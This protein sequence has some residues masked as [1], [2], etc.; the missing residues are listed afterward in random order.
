MGIAYGP[1]SGATALVIQAGRTLQQ[2]L[3]DNGVT[4]SY[5]D[6][7]LYNWGTDDPR[8]VNRALVEL[9]GCQFPAPDPLNTVLAPTPGSRG[10]LN[11]VNWG[12][13]FATGNHHTV[14]VR[15]ITPGVAVS[16]TS[17]STFFGPGT[18]VTNCHIVFEIEGR[19]PAYS[20]Q[21]NVTATSGRKYGRALDPAA[22]SFQWNG[23]LGD[24]ASLPPQTPSTS[25]DGAC[26]VSIVYFKDAADAGT[27]LELSPF[28]PRWRTAANS[29]LVDPAS[30]VVQWSLIGTDTARAKLVH[31]QIQLYDRHNR[32]VCLSQLSAEQCQAASWDF[33]LYPAIVAGLT[34]ADMPYRVQVQCHSARDAPDGL[35]IATMP[36]QVPAYA[37]SAVQFTGFNVRNDVAP[38]PPPGGPW[39]LGHPDPAVDIA[40]RCDVMKAAI[41]TAVNHMSCDPS[42]DTLKVFVA[43]EFFFRGARGAYPVD[44]LDKVLETLRAETNQPKYVD[45]LFVFGT[46]IGQLHHESAPTQRSV[47]NGVMHIVQVQTSGVDQNYFT[48]DAAIVPEPGWQLTHAGGWIPIRGHSA[49][50]EGMAMTLDVGALALAPGPARLFEP[51]VV[52]ATS[53]DGMG[54]P[55]INV[56][57]RLL[58]NV[59]L[60]TGGIALGGNRWLARINGAVYEILYIQKPHQYVL[61]LSALASFAVGQFVSLIEPLSTE[62]FNVAMVQKGW[63]SGTPGRL[64]DGSLASAL[65]YK[66]YISPIDFKTGTRDTFHEPTGGGRTVFID[67]MPSRSVMPLAGSRDIGGASPSVIRRADGVGSEINQSGLGGGCVLTINGVTIGLEVCLDHAV[68]R[69]R[70]FYYGPNRTAQVNDPKVQVQIIPSWG[71]SIGG[72]TPGEEVSVIDNGLIFNVDG[73]RMESVLRA[74]NHDYGCDT[75]AAM[76]SMVAGNCNRSASFRSSGVD[77]MKCTHPSH[78]NPPRASGLDPNPRFHA[79]GLSHAWYQNVPCGKPLQR[80]GVAIVKLGTVAFGANWIAAGFSVPGKLDIFP[81]LALPLPQ[82]V[83]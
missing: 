55:M 56:D 37:Y 27:R 39:Y 67:G 7:A 5:R 26:N 72:G 23:M 65:V 2:V 82:V 12:R 8:A 80:M 74:W 13:T 41:Q 59:S 60:P 68:G 33:S 78:A 25:D 53:V 62:I 22:A 45:W 57:A 75:H 48:S 50:A 54:N 31:G 66:E 29:Y 42:P 77:Y 51:L 38:N 69:L 71:M 30:L 49:V 63:H 64:A 43:P 73:S 17:L 19:D 35:A 15:R 28:F 34:R 52:L 76:R 21:L 40:Q 70:H 32:L 9:V 18:P 10:I 79:C 81:T 61:T 20:C 3:T 11:P 58:S 83:T 16:I 14:V 24:T 44:Q 46:A 36:T 47:H 6:I 1:R 4:A